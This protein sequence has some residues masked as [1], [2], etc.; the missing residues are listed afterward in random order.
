MEKENLEEKKI[1][2]IF[3]SWIFNQQIDISNSSINQKIDVKELLTEKSIIDLKKNGIKTIKLNKKLKIIL[4]RFKN[5]IKDLRKTKNLTSI[6]IYNKFNKKIDNA[7]IINKLKEITDL[8]NQ[9]H[10]PDL[11]PPKINIKKLSKNTILKAKNQIKI[12]QNIFL[13]NIKK[14]LK[15]QSKKP[16]LNINFKK[17]LSIFIWF[18]LFLVIY[19]SIILYNSYSLIK[20]TKILI[21]NIKT[22]EIDINQINKL[23]NN[24]ITLNIFL[25]PIYWLNY[26]LNLNK[27]ND[28]KY[29]IKAY[30]NF[31]EASYLSFY[32]MNKTK[33]LIE[34]KWI[35]NIYFTNLFYNSDR[36]LNKIYNKFM[37][38]LENFSK[39]Q[40][41]TFLIKNQDLISQIETYIPIIKEKLTLIQKNK[42][43]IYDI[44]GHNKE[45]KY[46][47]LLQNADE[48]RPM[49]WFMWSIL[50]ISIFKWKIKDF[51]FNDIYALEW[52]IKDFSKRKTW[53]AFE[54]PALEWIN[55]LTN[56]FGLRDANYFYNI[57]ESSKKISYFL[58]K[59]WL[60]VD[61]I[62]YINQNIIT[63]FLKKIWWVYFP[64][65]N[66]T[67][68]DK[69]FSTV[70][71][72]I[73][74]SKVT[75]THTLWT[76][77]KW[78]FDFS[79][80]FISDLK[81]KLKL[82]DFYEVMMKSFIKNDIIVDFLDEEK[83]NFKDKLIGY[84]YYNFLNY[85]N[86]FYPV[87]TSISWNKSDR[88]I[89]RNFLFDIKEDGDKYKINTK[90]ELKHNIKIN[91]IIYIK[92]LMYDLGLLWKVD[93]N[94]L[95]K[96][97]W[98]DTNKQYIRIL[99]PK[100]AILSNNHFLN[101]IK[102]KEF[103]NYKEISFY[104][105]TEPFLSS[106]FEF[107]YLLDKK[108]NDFYFKKQPWIKDYS[109]KIEKN[110]ILIKDLYTEKDFIL[111]L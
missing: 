51:K 55:K 18:I 38:S 5:W 70:I 104:L 13:K 59:A 93:E 76:P 84:N 16:N 96:I 95:L 86:F 44:L 71:S 109:I 87:F 74:E 14:I 40:N 37:L 89:T 105:N 46:V 107:E 2:D 60:K 75:H 11:I 32:F 58:D 22:K 62:I 45:K 98:N 108:N 94:T 25:T 81:Q 97:A 63:Q 7:I 31:L 72:L 88:F 19:S 4:K 92:S 43:L 53:I 100:N 52:K 33:E 102:V 1:N 48:I 79:S 26:L 65:F 111:K 57:E 24:S 42:N 68:D 61:W 47:I 15:N 8:W 30:S 78:L 27:I 56:T 28:I 67:I 17:I 106:I 35:E 103:E 50:E 64:D 39:I 3:L 6:F 21:N 82:S 36:L 29:F 80:Y 77:K 54:E 34:K 99:L 20:N 10:Y 91:D 41:K 49:W 83:N 9:K 110:W 73:T 69:N 66:I 101:S 90:I 12:F 85:N 23:K